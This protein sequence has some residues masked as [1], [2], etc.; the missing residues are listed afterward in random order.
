LIGYFLTTTITSEKK[1]EGTE[2][3]TTMMKQMER[4]T[5]GASWIMMEE[6]A[7]QLKQDLH[8]LR[9]ERM[10]PQDFYALFSLIARPQQI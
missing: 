2:M 6:R 4:I 8:P 5:P 7:A 10:T 9:P 1:Q 3:A